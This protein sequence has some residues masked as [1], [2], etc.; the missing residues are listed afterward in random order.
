MGAPRSHNPLAER[1]IIE[2]ALKRN[3][4]KRQATAAELNLDRTTLC[5]MRKY[6]LDIG[7]TNDSARLIRIR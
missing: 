3:P 7:E 2:G 5:K 6:Q 4:Y 1:H